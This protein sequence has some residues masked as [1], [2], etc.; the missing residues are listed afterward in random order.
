MLIHLEAGQCSASLE[1]I[2]RLAAE[3]FQ[4][5]KYVHP[6]MID[7]LRD[8]FRFSRRAT[9]ESTSD[10]DVEWECTACDRTFETESDA[11]KHVNSP[12]HDEYLYYCPSCH[13]EFKV[14]SALVQHVESNRCSATTQP[15]TP[16]GKMLH[17]IEMS[18]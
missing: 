8:G 16:I 11:K 14:P 7:Y 15:G 2:D 10:W 12:V 4:A 18:L 6:S 1:E 17:Y 5:K 13:D 3:C 9:Y